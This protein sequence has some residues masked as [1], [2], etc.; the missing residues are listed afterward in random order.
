[1]T[2]LNMHQNLL[3]MITLRLRETDNVLKTLFFVAGVI[4]VQKPVGMFFSYP[5]PNL[6]PQ[7]SCLLIKDPK[8]WGSPKKYF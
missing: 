8:N 6:S 4:L 5:Q 3:I 1:M 7:G 2:Q